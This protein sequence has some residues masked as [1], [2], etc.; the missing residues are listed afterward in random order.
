MTVINIK[1]NMLKFGKDDSSERTERLNS[2]K[3]K[4]LREA[5]GEAKEGEMMTLDQYLFLEHERL[6]Q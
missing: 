6:R 4:M 2:P 5:L 3:N 1:N